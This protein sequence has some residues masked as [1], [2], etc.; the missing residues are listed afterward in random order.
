M[1]LKWAFE[2]PDAQRARSHPLI[3]GGAVF[4]GSQSGRVYALD[5][6]SGCVR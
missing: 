4:V 5:A 2:Y 3:A 1:Y 6:E